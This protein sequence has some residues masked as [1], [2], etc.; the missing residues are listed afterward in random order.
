MVPHCLHDCQLLA[1]GPSGTLEECVKVVL[2]GRGVHGR[3]EAASSE[4]AQSWAVMSLAGLF[5]T[6]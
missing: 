2:E 1:R 5:I 4:Q 6:W 3:R